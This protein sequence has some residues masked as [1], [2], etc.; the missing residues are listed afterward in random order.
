MSNIVY[1]D[2]ARNRFVI[3][4]SVLE[5]KWANEYFKTKSEAIN[6]IKQNH[7]VLVKKPKKMQ[8]RLTR[9]GLSS[10]VDDWQKNELTLHYQNDERLYNRHL[11]QDWFNNYKRKIERGVFDTKLAIK[12]LC[13]FVDHVIQDY[14]KKYG[15]YQLQN[16][17]DTNSWQ[18]NRATKEA[19]AEEVLEDLMSNFGL[20]EIQPKQKGSRRSRIDYIGATDPGQTPGEDKFLI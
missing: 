8:K 14:R 7:L 19:I 15:Q 17:S 18:V 16:Y 11:G 1:L 6:F 10:G 12:G 3:I 9:I 13:I 20:A 2:I 4:D 5:Q